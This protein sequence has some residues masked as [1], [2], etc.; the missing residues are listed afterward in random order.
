[1]K[2]FAVYIGGEMKGANIEVHDIRFVAAETI[3]DTYAELRRQWWGIPKSL[4]LDCWAAIDSADG[5]EVTLRPEP[6][7]GAEKLYYVNLGG[8]DRN[9]FLEKHRN[10]FVVASSEADAKTRAKKLAK[11]WDEPHRDDM[12]EAEQAFALDSSVASR[13]LFIHLKATPGI[14]DFSFTCDYKRIG[15]SAASWT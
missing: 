2:L 14:A 10:A 4:H 3:T 5:Y 9:E 1:M 8:Y 15:R 13:R 11:G 12:Y 7:D 6:F